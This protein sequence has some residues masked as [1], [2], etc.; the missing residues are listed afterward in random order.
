MNRECLV[1]K[2]ERGFSGRF[3]AMASPCEV[4]IDCSDKALAE[5]ITST[6]AS[7][8]WRIESKFSRYRDDNIVYGINNAKGKTVEVDQETTHLIDFATHAYQI[9]DR[10]FDLSSGVLRRVWTF[11]G[12]NNIPHPE[13]VTAIL[14]IIGWHKVTWS[15]PHLTLLPDMEIDFGGIGKEYA[16]DKAAALVGSLSDVPVLINFGGDLFANAPPSYQED[17]LVGV[18]N[19]GGL[20]SAII[21]L[22]RGGL[23]TSGD[24][25]RFLL[26]DGVRYPHVL[27]PMTG[28][29]VMDAPHSVT[30]ATAS[31]V[32][33]GLLATLSML[34]GKEAEDFLQAQEVLHWVQR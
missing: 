32:E 15:A 22:Q 30:V 13:D 24:A 16:V 7:E 10:L 20:Q 12:G 3:N 8:A 19:I 29:P 28:W 6:V 11:D 5:K 9:S 2:T 31:C 26:R 33:A 17:W 25:R 21:Q 4:L 1:T 34:Q 23:A 18:E 27:N 14:P